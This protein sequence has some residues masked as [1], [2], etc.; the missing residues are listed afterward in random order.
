MRIPGTLGIVVL[1]CGA[2]VV[3]YTLWREI[4]PRRF[5]GIVYDCETGTPIAG[6][7]VELRQTTI[8]TWERVHKYAGETDA[9]GRLSI[10]YNVGDSVDV[11]TT[12]DG[13]LRSEHFASGGRVRIGIVRR[14]KTDRP[15]DYT[16]NC[17][18]SEECYETTIVNGVQTTRNTCG[19]L[20]SQ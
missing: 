14:S 15:N 20:P 8:F 7:R 18:R 16:I 9:E 2:L 6:V 17:K 12:K 11:I 5:S 19:T 1:G 4:G 3:A 13:Y 10:W